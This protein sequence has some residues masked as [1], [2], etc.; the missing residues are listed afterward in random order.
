[1]VYDKKGEIVVEHQILTD[2]MAKPEGI[3]LEDALGK[4]HKLYMDFLNKINALNLSPEW[5]YY[6]DGKSW[7]CKLLNK[8]KNMCWLSVWNTGFK[9][10]FYFAEK[11]IGGIYELDIDNEIK[12]SAKEM[13]PVGKSHPVILLNKKKKIMNDGLKILEY[14]ISQ[15]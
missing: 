12:S 7:L 9:L 6:N 15:K 3:V 8:K 2:P 4:N 11:A 13:K 10:T 1:V 5:N 14:K